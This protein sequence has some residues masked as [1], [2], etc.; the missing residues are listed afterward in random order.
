MPANKKLVIIG[1][2]GFGRECL[3]VLQA[4]I[5][6]GAEF[7]IVGVVDDNP[8]R[9]NLERLRNRNIRY[10]GTVAEWLVNLGDEGYVLGIGN[11]NVRR[12]VAVELDAAGAQAASLVHPHSTIGSETTLADGVVIC[13]GVTVSTNVR[14]GRHVHINPNVTIGHDTELREFVSINPGAVVSGEV[15]VDSGTLV[16]A[17]A[18]IL[19]QLTIGKRSVVGAG[20]VVTRDVPSGVTVKGVPGRWAKEK[21]TEHEPT[22][23][24]DKASNRSSIVGGI[25]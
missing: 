24:D 20:S 5:L 23:V 14:I 2:S 8:S 11:P 17:A 18:I 10:V 21:G 4:M 22:S 25:Q 15:V 12:S 1:A 9:I 3:D 19:Q 13:A 7:D 16:G 6:I